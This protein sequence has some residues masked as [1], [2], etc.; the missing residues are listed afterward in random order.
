MYR[1]DRTTYDAREIWMAAFL[2]A[3]GLP[4]VRCYLNSEGRV[5]WE[6]GDRDTAWQLSR[7]WLDETEQCRIA[8]PDLARSYR[9]MARASEAAG[10]HRGAGHGQRAA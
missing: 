9:E 2:H 8:G 4:Y 3:A 7:A 1:E 6:F 10:W 5:R